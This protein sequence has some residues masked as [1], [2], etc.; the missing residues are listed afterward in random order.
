MEGKQ[1]WV[2]PRCQIGQEFGA[3]SVACNSKFFT[4]NENVSCDQSK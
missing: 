3:L 4:I 1:A 2:N